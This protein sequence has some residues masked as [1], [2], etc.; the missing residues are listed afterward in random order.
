R[1]AQLEPTVLLAGD[2]YPYGGTGFDRTAEANE[3]AASLGDQLRRVVWVPSGFGSRLADAVSWEDAIADDPPADFEFE[4]V[5]FDH[6]LWVLFSSG[7]TGPPK[8]IMHGHGGI[9][10]EQLK[11]QGLHMDLHA[12]DRL[13]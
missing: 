1:L 2:G 6:P 5:A 8:A 10:L 4:Q 3:L 9:L 13:F 12:G 7:T 11:L